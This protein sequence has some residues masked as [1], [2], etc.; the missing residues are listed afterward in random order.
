MKKLLMKILLHLKLPF[1]ILYGLADIAYVVIYYVVGYRKK[2]VKE[3]LRNS[4]PEK[5]DK[6]IAK[7]S[8]IWKL[9]TIA[10]SRGNPS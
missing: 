1:W 10:S 4:F 7:F 6:E 8:G 2:V 3:N 9:P 5:T